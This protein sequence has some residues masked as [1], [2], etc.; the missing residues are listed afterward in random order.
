MKKKAVTDTK[1]NDS[2]ANENS[3][4]EGCSQLASLDKIHRTKKTVFLLKK[5]KSETSSDV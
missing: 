5:K 3:Y 2:S 4:F 1:N